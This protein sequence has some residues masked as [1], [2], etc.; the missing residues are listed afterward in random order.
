MQRA[1][2]LLRGRYLPEASADVFVSVGWPGGRGKKD[3]VIGQ[4]WYN[5]EGRNQLF[6]SPV[7]GTAEEVLHVLL[8]EMIHA[9]C[10][11]EVGHRGEFVALCKRVGLVKPWTAT[12]PGDELRVGLEE[13]AAELGPYPHEKLRPL[14]KKAVQK[15]YM[16]KLTC[17]G[18]GYTVRTTKKW[19]EVGNPV[20]PC[21]TG[22]ELDA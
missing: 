2:I 14:P 18:C 21:G 22:L 15:T 9:A 6:L 1:V 10:G 20:C 7:L 19:V 11:P 5:S 4:C 13:V 8:H 3:T 16:L 17:P 12:T